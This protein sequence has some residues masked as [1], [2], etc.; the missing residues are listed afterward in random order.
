MRGR[1]QAIRP[2]KRNCSV[3]AVIWTTS[4]L[5]AETRLTRFFAYAIERGWKQVRFFS[6]AAEE[7]GVAKSAQSCVQAQTALRELEP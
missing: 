2:F 3:N 7:C 1:Q 5:P 6:A 4:M